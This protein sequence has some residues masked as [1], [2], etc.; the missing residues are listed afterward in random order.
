MKKIAEKILL[1]VFTSK[2]INSF[3]YAVALAKSVSHGH[4]EVWATTWK[5]CLS[6]YVKIHIVEN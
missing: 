3:P 6:F 1:T 5:P 2:I 4:I